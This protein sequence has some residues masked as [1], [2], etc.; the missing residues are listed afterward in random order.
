MSHAK[1]LSPSPC[2]FGEEDFLNCQCMY[3]EGKPMTPG[4]GPLF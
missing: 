3:I 1:Y 2:G 4:A